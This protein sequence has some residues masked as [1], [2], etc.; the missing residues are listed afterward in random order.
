MT[1]GT[2]S[3]TGSI[4]YLEQQPWIMNDTM[5][6]N[7]LFGREYDAEFFARVIHGCALTEDIVV[8]P[9]A[10]LAAISE[11]G[12]N[13]PGGQRARLALAHTL[14][15]RVDIYVLDDPISAV[16]AHVKLHILEHVLL[17]T[18][19][20]AGKLRILADKMS[21]RDAPGKSNQEYLARLVQ[22]WFRAR[23]R[24]LRIKRGVV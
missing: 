23:S 11:R 18:G 14:Y 16:D 7:V 1:A 20:L 21:M 10:D 12:I 6:A 8:W 19:M 15:S 2:G 4:A 13:I 22:P 3:V 24:P 5:R 17:D 9:N